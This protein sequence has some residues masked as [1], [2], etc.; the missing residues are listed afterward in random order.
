VTPEEIAESRRHVARMSTAALAQRFEKGPEAWPA[1]AWAIL[2]E[3]VARRERAARVSRLQIAGVST[4][5]GGASVEP[6]F[7]LLRGALLSFL[8]LVSVGYCAAKLLEAP[9]ALPTCESADAEAAVRDAIENSVASRL[10]NHRL[11]DLQ[12]QTEVS[13]DEAKLERRCKAQAIMNSGGIAINYRLY[14]L[15]ATDATLLVEVTRK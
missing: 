15:S 9:T 13:Y 14:K 6:R 3:E 12:G 1:E 11:L 8:G 4:A 10:V 7:G 2:E 5:E